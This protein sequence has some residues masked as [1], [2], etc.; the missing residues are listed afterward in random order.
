[1]PY[2]LLRGVALRR[3]SDNLLYIGLSVKKSNLMYRPN[4]GE[5]YIATVDL[6]K[7]VVDIF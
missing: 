2:Y 4:I 6:Y 7:L 3:H 5:Q 1:M